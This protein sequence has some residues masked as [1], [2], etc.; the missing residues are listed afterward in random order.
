MNVYDS[1]RMA[2]V[3]AP[4]GF[5]VAESLEDADMVVL[6]TCHIR[7]KAAEKV[8]SELGRLNRLKRRRRASG[9]EFL[10]AVAG[11]VAQAEGEE[12]RR[13]APFVDIVCGPQAYHRLPELIERAKS[14]PAR[15]AFDTEFPVE[16]KF[17]HLPEAASPQGVSAFLSVQEGCDKFCTFC[18][19]PYTRGAELSRPVAAVLAEARRLVGHGAREITL[20][21]QNVNAYHGAAPGESAGGGTGWGLGRLVRALAAIEGL[22]RIRYT[23][24]HPL[25]MDDELI[26]AHR[27][28][29]ALMPFLHLP[30]QS[31][32][33]AVLAR[34]NRRHDADA[35]RRV[36]GRLR[37]ARP[38]LALSSDFIVGFPGESD[39]DFAATLRLVEDVFYAQAFSFKYS[40]RPGTPAAEMPDQVPEV[41]KAERLA[42]L[43]ALLKRQ[44]D[45]FNRA[46]VGQTMP[47][48][49]DRP[50]RSA[51]QLAGRS[52]WLQPV[53]VDADARDMGTMR[54]VRILAAHANSLAGELASQATAVASVPDAAEPE[55]VPA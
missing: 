54:D 52:P 46:A 48:L 36:V 22:R 37:A 33:D 21:G 10:I 20:L 39:A 47:V 51:G 5:A 40:P 29:P 30:V 19:V 18:V 23:T 13:R 55:R 34:M 44:Q 3:L 6:N 2:D 8:Y 35:Y 16:S 11:C 14:D 28:V 26:A 41:V 27:D 49:F 38:D 42:E 9:G 43:Q 7:E 4:L 24:S 15:G 12:M 53:H 1:A 31:G 32:S 50:G 17:D 25:D 45:R